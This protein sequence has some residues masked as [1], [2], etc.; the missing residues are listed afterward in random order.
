M[1]LLT[2]NM[3]L[4]QTSFDFVVVM[5]GSVGHQSHVRL[6]RWILICYHHCH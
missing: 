4:A 6:V 3:N 2:S 5:A 1:S